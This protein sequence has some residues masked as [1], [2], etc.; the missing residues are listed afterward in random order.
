MTAALLSGILSAF[1]LPVAFSGH[2]W[3]DLGYFAWVALI[4]LF[5]SLRNATA[6]QGV[7]RGFAFGCAHFGFSLYW[8]F[9]ALHRYGEVSA[10]DSAGGLMI[11]VV[12][13][14]LFP[15]AV[16]GTAV[17]LAS[18]KIPLWI[19][20]TL[21]WIGFEFLRNYFPF[22]GFSWA[23]LA[24]SQSG[25]LELLQMLDVTGVSGLLFLILLANVLGGEVW[26]W[27]KGR[28]ETPPPTRLAALFTVALLAAVVYGKVRLSQVRSVVAGLRTLKVSM[29]QGNIPQDEKW[30]DEK[31][32]EIIQ[33]H[34]EL[35]DRA[36][37]ASPNLIVWPEAAFPAVIPPDIVKIEEIGEVKK[38]ILMGAVSYDG[39]IPEDWPPPLPE[40][41]GDFALHNSA[42]LIEPG[43]F[44][45][46]HYHKVHLVPMGEYVP[47]ARVFFFLSKVAP[48][49]SSFTAG[50]EFNVMTAA[51]T[52]F[53]VTICYE[54]LFSEISR[55][56]TRKG[57]DFLINVTNDGWYE[58]SSA[59]YQ[60]FDFSRYRA[61]ENRRSMARA[62]NTGR[63]GFFSPTGEVIAEAPLFQEAAITA[64]VPVGGPISLYTHFGDVFAWCCVAALG[65][66]TLRR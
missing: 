27:V 9:I 59:I 35:T 25:H 24:Y 47:L 44:I 19:T 8:I 61:I 21:S 29:V 20:F 56:F 11:L 66:V 28:R 13:V 41:P 1:S 4:P 46:D 65:L 33:K 53:G 64:D 26:I 42:F 63:T 58:G 60:H 32:P 54:D 50:K 55:L 49:V 62:T 38:P 45:A 17:R 39:V 48:S 14:S 16:C 43:G 51:G 37:E 31:M 15:A 12:L 3:P 30:I 2:R 6:R 34:R 5:L 7:L 22:G 40:K 57:A 52:K 36:E 23:N 18:E 10:W